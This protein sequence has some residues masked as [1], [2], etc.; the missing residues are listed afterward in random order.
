MS[1]KSKKD[2]QPHWRPNF[3]IASTLPDIK[4]IRTDFIV[5][6]IAATIALLAAF[7]VI[8]NEFRAYMLRNSIGE[9]EQRIRV[10]EAGDAASLAMSGDFKTAAKQIVEVDTFYDAPWKAHELFAGLVEMKPEG[11]IFERVALNEEVAKAKDSSVVNYRVVMSGEVEELIELTRFKR[12][13]SESGVLNLE[14]YSSRIVESLQD[15]D[16][17]TGIYPYSLTIELTPD[18]TPAGDAEE[19]E[20]S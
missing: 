9:M 20:A 2:I 10:A 11:L 12:S 7:L 13:L 16:T 14:G 17:K 4:V 3:Q 1:K 19:G 18:A 15:R 5:N 8:Q 6:S